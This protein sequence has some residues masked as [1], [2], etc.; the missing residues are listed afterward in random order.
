MTWKSKNHFLWELKNFHDLFGI[1]LKVE[2]IALFHFVVTIFLIKLKRSKFQSHLSNISL[3][4]PPIG[5]RTNGYRKPR[6]Q[7]Q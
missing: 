5:H 3:S 6:T 2:I 1:V 7:N 4:W